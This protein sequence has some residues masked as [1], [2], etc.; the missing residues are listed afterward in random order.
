MISRRKIL[1]RSQSDIDYPYDAYAVEEDIWYD[2]ENLYTVS[3][4]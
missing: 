1:S 4:N 3:N 2:K